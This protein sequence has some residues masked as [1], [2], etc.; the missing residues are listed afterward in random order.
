MPIHA[1]ASMIPRVHSG[2]FRASSVSSMRNTNL[3]PNRL[4]KAQLYNAVRAPPTWKKPVGDGANRNRGPL[5]IGLPP[6]WPHRLTTPA[7]GCARSRRAQS[8]LRGGAV[9]GEDDVV[10][11][12]Q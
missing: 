10:Q 4:A 5:C 6:Y 9:G 8:L 7:P 1:S 2:R 12:A 3:P 11:L